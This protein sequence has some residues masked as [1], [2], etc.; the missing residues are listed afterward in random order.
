MASGPEGREQQIL[1]INGGSSSIRFALYRIAE[2][3]LRL[4][5]GKLDRVDTPAMRLTFDDARPGR[6]GGQVEAGDVPASGFLLDWLAQQ[7]DIGTLR[8]VG[9]RIVHGLQHS[10]PQPVGDALLNDLR[11]TIG[12]DPDHLPLEIELIDAFRR[13]HPHLPQLACFDTAFHR[14]LPRV[15]QLLPIPRRYQAFG[16]R[17]YGFHGLSYGYLMQRLAQIDPAAARGRVILAHLGNGASMAAVRDGRSMDTSMGLTPAGGL[18]M[19]T[20]PGD[21]DPGVAGYLLHEGGLDA[22]R[23]SDLVNHQSGLLGVSDS[24]A[25]M[26]DLL[27]RERD[28]AHA[29]EAVALFCYQARKTIGAYAAVLNGLDTLVFS[30][31]IG[32]NAAPVRARICDGLQYLGLELDAARN[33]AAADLISGAASCVAVRVIPTDEE[34]MIASTVRNILQ[35]SEHGHPKGSA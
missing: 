20:R 33:G 11:R 32:E 5:S 15:A 9:H 6:A 31:G 12:L 14:D 4:L 10:A 1:A 17:R 22:R 27:A 24:S 34:W 35:R 8:A 19:G 25:D 26:R 29:A 2:Q 18:V 7:V 16:L 21:L 23:F 3:P 13:R 28:D 30:G